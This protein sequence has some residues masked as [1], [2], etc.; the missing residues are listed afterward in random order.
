MSCTAGRGGGSPS[1]DAESLESLEDANMYAVLPVP[2]TEV[3]A[4]IA[5]KLS[6]CQPV[7]IVA[8]NRK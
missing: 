8:C 4:D 2:E 1:R 7:K 6:T 3:I 5:G